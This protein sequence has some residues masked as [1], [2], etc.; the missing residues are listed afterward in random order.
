MSIDLA[1]KQL[2]IGHKLY[3]NNLALPDFQHFG[4]K[5]GYALKI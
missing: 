3:I 2:D 4:H 1:I 5:F